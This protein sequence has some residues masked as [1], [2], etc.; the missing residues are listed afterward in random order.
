MSTP[1]AQKL[2]SDGEISRAL[3]NLGNYRVIAAQEAALEGPPDG[4][5]GALLLALGLRETRLKNINNPA[6]TDKGCFQ[7]TERYHARFLQNEAGCPAGTWRAVE[8]H[9][10]YEDGYCP[11]FTPALNY[12]L[13]ML[14]DNRA[15]AVGQGVPKEKAVQFA[16]AAYNAGQSGALDGWRA[17]DVDLKTTGRDYSRWCMTTRVLIQHWVEAHPG[18]QPGP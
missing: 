5:S 1:G 4:I 15:F 14:K 2:L 13:Q 12:A 16:V 8:G 7:I 9:S 11:R 3:A 10:A 6:E 18:W 17:G